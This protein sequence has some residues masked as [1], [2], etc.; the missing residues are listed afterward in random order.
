[1]TARPDAKSLLVCDLK[2]VKK[3]GVQGLGV[4]AGAQIQAS[5]L[6][7]VQRKGFRCI[8]VGQETQP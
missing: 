5:E 8:L 1:M 4:V 2:L 3:K 7:V 6:Q